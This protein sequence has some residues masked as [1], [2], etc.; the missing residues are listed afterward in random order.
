MERGEIGA[1]GRERRESGRLKKK[2]TEIDE[3]TRLAVP[4]PLARPPIQSPPLM[5]ARFTSPSADRALYQG[6]ALVVTGVKGGTDRSAPDSAA[7]KRDGRAAGA[8][9]RRVAGIVRCV[10]CCVLC[11]PC[12]WL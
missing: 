10:V 11:G 2:K 8:G 5:C 12:L 3:G 1:D 9:A 4:R 6:V 7:A